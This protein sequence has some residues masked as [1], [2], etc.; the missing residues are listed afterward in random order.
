MKASTMYGLLDLERE[1]ADAEMARRLD[2]RWQAELYG[3]EFELAAE[4]RQRKR[5]ADR[6]QWRDVILPNIQK[7]A[8][9]N[10]LA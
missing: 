8:M 4:E 10:R 6:R 1:Y 2:L 3:L 5:E 7:Q 9:L